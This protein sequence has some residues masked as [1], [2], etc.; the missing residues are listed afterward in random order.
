MPKATGQLTLPIDRAHEQTL[1]NFV[2]GP[3]AELL[4]TLTQAWVEFRG[5]WLCGAR[6]VG[7]SHLLRGIALDQRGIGSNR[8]LYVDAS[9]S[10]AKSQLQQG[11][12]FG[13]VVAVDNVAEIAGDP[14]AEEALMAIYE[15]LRAENG[16]LMLSHQL[17]AAAVE[18]DLADLNS[19]MRSLMHYQLAPLRDDEKAEVLKSRAAHRGYVLSDAVLSYW[20]ARGPRELQLLL[21]D[22]DRLD[23]ASLQAQRHVTVPLLKE[24]LGY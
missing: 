2:P 14:E 19:R 16:L 5:F 7:K 21:T 1:E 12:R 3:N 9:L 17:A 20:L 18:F 11:V 15:R 13:D 6:G 22:L 4:A 24:V 10:A 23:R 8:R